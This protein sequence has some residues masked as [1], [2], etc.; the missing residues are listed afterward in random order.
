VLTYDPPIGTVE[1]QVELH[2]AG[3]PLTARE[4]LEVAAK[5]RGISGLLPEHG[6]AIL[7]VMMAWG[8]RR[9]R[10]VKADTQKAIRNVLGID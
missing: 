9:A 4:F 8:D 5:V 7:D 1:Q 3:P 2:S 10:R 6:E